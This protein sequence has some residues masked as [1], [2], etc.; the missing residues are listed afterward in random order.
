MLAIID[1]ESIEAHTFTLH[2]GR[3]NRSS[4]WPVEP[5][6]IDKMLSFRVVKM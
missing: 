1:Y 3:A 2:K 6:L 5:V 4:N